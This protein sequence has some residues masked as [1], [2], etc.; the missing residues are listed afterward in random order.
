[1]FYQW[2]EWMAE[3]HSDYGCFGQT[4]CLFCEAIF[5]CPVG[6]LRQCQI[7]GAYVSP[8]YMTEAEHYENLKTN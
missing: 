1:M 5:G 6:W 7:L 4:N 8:S 3:T 2:I